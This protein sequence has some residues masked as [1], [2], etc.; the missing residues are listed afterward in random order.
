MHEGVDRIG[1]V[2]LVVIVRLRCTL[3]AQERRTQAHAALP[4]HHALPPAQ[5]VTLAEAS[6][7]GCMGDALKRGVRVMPLVERVALACL[8]VHPQRHATL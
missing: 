8:A 7:H 1:E 6:E 5:R 2:E 3:G 4:L